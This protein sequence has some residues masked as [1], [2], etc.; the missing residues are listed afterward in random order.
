MHL[1]YTI[2]YNAV[3]VLIGLIIIE[4]V[5]LMKE[6]REDKKNFISS[7]AIALLN[8]P[9]ST[10]T[11]L[12][13][14]YLYTFIYDFRICSISP[15]SW[16]AW[17]F[18]VF[19]DELSYYWFHRISHQ[20]RLLW[21][22]HKVHHSS[23]KFTLTSGLRVPWTGGLTGSF[24]FWAWLPFVGIMPFMVLFMKSLAAL[25]QFW[26]HTET[27]AKMP[28]WF[29]AIF[30]TPSHHRVHHSSDIMYLDKNYGGTMIVYDK[31][32]GTY[33]DEIFTPK[34]GLTSDI[35]S[36]NPFK[37]ELDEWKNLITDLKRSKTWK[38]RVRYLFDSPGWSP[39]ESYKTTK[40]LQLELK[41]HQ[42]QSAN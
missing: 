8:V 22:S 40:K 32:F 27:I 25:Y 4:S 35:D 29:E 23:Q 9:F 33:Q 21:A 42:E 11:N 19:A 7:V 2:L 15:H 1:N 10:I 34:Y 26:L 3:P 6:K 31:V 28:I 14:L 24:L 20:T 12:A 41:S 17:I 38:D 37:I 13:G 18:L 16:M 5:F 36:S 39:E 30:N